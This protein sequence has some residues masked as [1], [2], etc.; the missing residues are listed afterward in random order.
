MTELQPINSSAA[1]ETD[2]LRAVLTRDRSQDGRFVYGVT[3]TGI[4]CRPS[5]PSRKP[6]GE[7]L[8][9]FA[10]PEAA[11][12]AG[13]RA[14]RRCRPQH[15]T[16]PD[17]QVAAVRRAC[18]AILKHLDEGAEGPPRLER[19]A[20]AAGMSPWHLQRTFTR[21]LGI[22]P[23]HFADAR[24]LDLLKA[25]LKDRS[26][27]K[28]VAGAVYGAGYGSASRVYERAGAELGMT[29]ATYAKGGAGADINFATAKTRLGLVL[30][31]ATHRGV[32]MVSLGAGA[33]KLE[34][35]LRAEYPAA[36]I[37]RDERALRPLLDAVV[38]HLAGKEPHLDLP[39]D[40]RATA[41]QWRVWQELK[42]IPLGETLSYGEIAARIGTPRAV[43]AVGHACAT[44][45]VA[46]TVPCHRA[47]RQDGSPGGYRWGLERKEKL[48]AAERQATRA[49]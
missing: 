8:R 49:K 7:N 36:A 34:A 17:P 27:G 16:A 31:A 48:L 42:A 21:L 26:N 44:N 33:E 40:V 18:T 1:P 6:K 30:V 3:S 22:S 47:V 13:F 29:P 15:I 11:E 5:C 12:R 35:A 43:R 28:G 4:Y 20:A 37:R 41:F 2:R 24:R 25:G 32:C 19:I 23:R 45:P 46:L 38:R 10:V 14:C 39:L 9:F